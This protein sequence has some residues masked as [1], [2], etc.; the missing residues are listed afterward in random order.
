M[1]GICPRCGHAP[2]VQGAYH[3]P[4][5]GCKHPNPVPPSK[6]QNAIALA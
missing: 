5:C 4:N 6:V 3:C 2:V 1:L